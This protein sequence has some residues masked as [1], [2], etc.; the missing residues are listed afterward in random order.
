MAA[1]FSRFPRAILLE[2]FR[3]EAGRAMAA[4][5]LGVV[6][7]PVLG[8]TLGGWLT[9]QYS[10]R[11]AFYINVPVGIL[12]ILMILRFV[13]DPPYIQKPKSVKLIRSD[14]ACWLCGWALCKLYWTR[15]RKTI[16]SRRIGFAGRPPLRS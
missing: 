14:L 15:D 6:V 10:W 1:R 3:A 8:P 13:K 9:D 11:W 4:F 12:A 5:G 2:S 7:A 16:G